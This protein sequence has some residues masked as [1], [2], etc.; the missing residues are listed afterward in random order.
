MKTPKLT[1]VFKISEM[2]EGRLSDPQA[3]AFIEKLW[4][5]GKWVDIKSARDEE[6]TFEMDGKFYSVGD[7]NVGDAGIWQFDSTSEDAQS[8]YLGSYSN[9]GGSSEWDPED[10]ARYE[11][12]VKK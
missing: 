2:P 4:K 10:M 6:V 3:K 7:N 5:R 8:K 12:T 11:D 1:E 9:P